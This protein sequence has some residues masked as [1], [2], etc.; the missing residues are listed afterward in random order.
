MSARNTGRTY[1]G[2]SREDRA[3]ERR[4]QL[5]EAGIK[6]I[7]DQGY[8]ATTVKAIC[9]EAG[10]TERYFYESFKNRE[11]LL[12][13]VYLDLVEWLHTTLVSAAA[14]AEPRTP[15]HIARVTLTRFYAEL[16]AHAH[17]ARIIYVEI[18]GVSAEMNETYRKCT[19]DFA[20]MLLMLT[21]PLF[22]DEHIPGHD[23]HLMAT[24]LVGAVNAILVQWMLNDFDKPLETVV[25]TTLDLFTA[26]T[27]HLLEMAGQ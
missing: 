24:G 22:P 25:E 18:M 10:L 16:R 2:K 9:N 12:E 4:G 3:A 27:R 6:V 14:G 21:R 11:A 8:A 1:G 17:I 5:V 26:L 23:E 20:D 19:G 13:A 7:G 15:E